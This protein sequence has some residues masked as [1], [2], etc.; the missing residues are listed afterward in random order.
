MSATFSTPQFTSLLFASLIGR[1]QIMRDIKHANT[2][3]ENARFTGFA[4]VT[5]VEN[6]LLQYRETGLLA[7]ASGQTL[8]AQRAYFY[9][10][11]DKTLVIFYAD[12]AQIGQEFVALNFSMPK[13]SGHK[14]SCLHACAQHLCG[15]DHYDVTFRLTLPT[16]FSTFIIVH[17]P[18]KSYVMTTQYERLT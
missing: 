11:V 10:L 9:K 16:A 2:H 17:G 15:E 6:S 7:L 13:D 18:R 14:D 5:K 1:W 3:G 12:G 4:V 8:T